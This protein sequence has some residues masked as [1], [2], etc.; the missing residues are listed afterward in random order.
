M[1]R[2]QANFYQIYFTRCSLKHLFFFSNE[3]PKRAKYNAKGAS[4]NMYAQILNQKYE[5]KA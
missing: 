2:D 3:T 5:I 1:L 4:L